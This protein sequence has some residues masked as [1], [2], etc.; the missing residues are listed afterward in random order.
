MVKRI[1][2]VAA[3]LFFFSTVSSQQ[4]ADTAEILKEFTKVMAFASVPDLYYT[5]STTISSEPVLTESDT[6]SIIGEFYK[7]D[8][9]IYSGSSREEVYLQDSLLVE[10]NNE[11]KSISLRRVDVSTKVNLNLLPV[12]NDELLKKFMKQYI[13]SKSVAGPG[14]FRLYFEERK[15]PYSSSATTTSIAIEYSEKDYLPRLIEIVGLLKQPADETVMEALKAEEIDESKLVKQIDGAAVLVRKQK[16][17]I[18][19]NQIERDKSRFMQMP[20]YRSV[21]DYDAGSQEFTGK[22][23]Y[24]DYE[25]TKTF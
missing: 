11:R 1:F 17:S 7:R 25:I 9:E 10:V 14:I 12:A 23:R 20:S 2:T 3:M 16:M 8:T 22:G 18:V 15:S 21:V 4:T 19:F 5:T 6:L 24:K 13:I